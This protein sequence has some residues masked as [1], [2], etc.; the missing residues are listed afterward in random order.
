MLSV[1]PSLR[2]SL[3]AIISIAIFCATA[4][5]QRI[6]PGITDPPL[7]DGTQSATQRIAGLKVPAGLTVSLFAAEPKLASPVAICLDEKGRVFVAEEY[8]FNRGTEENR[9]RPFLLDDDLQLKTVEDRLEM[10]RKFA[11]RFDGGLEWFTRY[12]DQVRLLTDKDGDGQADDS[13]IFAAQFNG[14]LDGLAAGVIARDGDVYLTNIPK[15]WRLRDEDGDGAAEK[16]EALLDGFGV[17]AA[18]LG[19]DLHGLAWGPD[20]R[21][22]FSVGDRGFAVK[23]K[24]GRTLSL[25]RR[26]AVFRCQPDGTEFEVIHIGLR[27]PQEL[28]FDEHG[29]LFTAD[30]NCDK[31]DHSRLVW[32]VPGGDSGWNMAYQTIPAPYETGPWHAEHIWHLNEPPH[33]G[34]L[35][36]GEG[37]VRPAWTL[38]PLGKLGAGPSGFAY[39]ATICLPDAFRGRFFLCNYTGNGGIETFRVEAKG[40]AFELTDPQDFLKPMSITDCDFGYDG[41]LYLSDFVGLDWNGASRGGRIY[42]VYDKQQIESGKIAEL[43][44]L[45]RQGFRDRENDELAELLKHADM[46]VRLRAQWALAERGEKAV[47]VFLA[48]IMPGGERLLRLHGIWGLGQIGRKQPEVLKHLAPLLADG[49]A[50]ICTQAA[51]TLGDARFAPTG[52]KLLPLSQDDN[53]RVRFHAAIALGQL[54]HKPA[55]GLLAELLKENANRDK[56]LRH[57]AVFALAEIGDR[58]AVQKLAT[59]KNAAVRLAA[60]LAMRRWEDAGIARF[61]QDDDI[62]IVTEAARAI[63]DLPL[64]AGTGELAKLAG[65]LLAGSE[66]VPEPLARR[67][68][69]ANFRLGGAD[70][71]AAIARIAASAK[72]PLAIRREAIAALADWKT[73]PQR[74]RVTG[75]WR[76]LPGRDVTPIRPAVEALAPAILAASS[77]EL[78]AA[79]AN[80]VAKLELKMDDAT[81]VGWVRD[82]KRDVAA[83]IAALDVLALHK[84]AEL[85]TLVAEALKEDNAPLR[86]AAIRLFTE[87]SPD[88]AV[89]VL[90]EILNRKV[91][92]AA[93][94]LTIQ[95]QQQAIT[96]LA[97]VESPAAT[98]VLLKCLHEMQYGRLPIA[99]RLDFWDAAAERKAAG[100]GDLR[101]SLDSG[102]ETHPRA[103][104]PWALVG[105]DADKGRE[106]FLYNR[107][108]QC[109]RCHKA[110]GRGGDAGPDLSKV[111]MRQVRG[112]EVADDLKF[113]NSLLLQGH[114]LQSIVVPDHQIAPGFGSVNLR[115]VDGR[116]LAGVLKAESAEEVQLQM[117][118]GQVIK[119]A[120]A[121]IE[122]RTQPKSAM[123][124]MDKIL[125]LRELRDLVE[126][127]TTL[128]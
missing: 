40:A 13:S 125:S 7:P 89:P 8:R 20:G 18:F 127:L 44:Q 108:A 77:G 83:R 106:V 68:I 85:P 75:N 63:N 60:L 51:K 100:L 97:R 16:R 22:Y 107:Q 21:L 31:G 74:D 56:H 58:P 32:I 67:I 118:D 73:P 24:E 47:G 46:R 79:A 128:K 29:N 123:P 96:S 17:N 81:F 27:N 104:L 91:P 71:A 50:E 65:S 110:E 52:E 66:Q 95:E 101:A 94:G 113:D 99:L 121:D 15:L 48:A 14:P 115:L 45:F 105:G 4:F 119:I 93:R 11:T 12:T 80:L 39:N 1:S 23:T 30:N 116:I 28:A 54:K 102:Y 70:Q 19:H 86:R 84:H 61:L 88:Q 120:A 43:A 114:L 26:G 34:P 64:D 55:V 41:K 42:T 62:W 72:L 9:T 78:A 3:F 124:A 87:T 76:P 90:A 82:S 6:S 103:K 5:G 37:D 59:D 98:Q 117:P 2:L 10:Y 122:A 109:S 25:P 38:P 57:A 112:S 35:P 36:E 33:P 69:N 53:L 92:L 111:G 49:D 126:Y